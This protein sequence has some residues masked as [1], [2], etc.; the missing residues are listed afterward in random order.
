MATTIPPATPQNINRTANTTTE[1]IFKKMAGINPAD[2]LTAEKKSELYTCGLKYVWAFGLLIVSGI[3]IYVASTDDK[4]LTE[5]VFKHMVFTILPIV[6]GCILILPLFSQKINTTTLVFNGIILI[7]VLLSVYAFYEIKSPESV[8]F[9]RY[10]MYGLVIFAL[11]VALAIIYKIYIRYIYNKRGWVFSVIQLIFFIPCLLLDFIEYIKSELKVAPKT[12]YVLFAIELLLVIAYIIISHLSR[13]SKKPSTNILLDEPVFLNTKTQVSD[14][15]T[16]VM[17]N[18]DESPFAKQYEFHANYSISFW[19][20][21]NA[22]DTSQGVTLLRIGPSA[23]KLVYGKPHI[24]YA[25]GVCSFY[26]TTPATLSR[27]PTPQLTINVPLQKWNYFAISYDEH[28]VNVFVNGVLEKTYT[29]Q[30]GE[31]PE[32]NITDVITVGSNISSMNVGAI[33]NIRYYKK[34]ITKSE[35]TSEYNRLMYSNPPTQ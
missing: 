20:F 9:V 12:V 17:G 14:Y 13:V 16:F 1:Y 29:F 15:K 26:L 10:I 6:I 28:K 4:A 31:T 30:D 8:M 18:I 2:E 25:N 33:C 5:G 3:F 34:P 23:T 21:L 27:N 19:A 7:V 11:I 22:V 32:Y 24:Q 35:V